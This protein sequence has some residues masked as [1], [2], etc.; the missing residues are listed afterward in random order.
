M[1]NRVLFET[2]MAAVRAR[3]GATVDAMLH[4]DLVI[5]EAPGLPYGGTFHGAAGW[6]ALNRAV[7]AA[8]GAMQVDVTEILGETADTL[9]VLMTLSG[10]AQATG[11]SFTTSILEI[12]RFTDGRI[13]AITPYYWD[14]HHLVQISSA[15]PPSSGRS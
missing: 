7:A 2:F 12:W 15:N 11:K 8:W 9:V 6:R 5:T 3:D 14:T 4:P 10:T 1:S 13:S